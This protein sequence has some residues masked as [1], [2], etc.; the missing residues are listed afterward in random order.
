MYSK[1]LK[2]AILYIN[3]NECSFAVKR[4]V[5][6]SASARSYEKQ[7]DS[8]CNCALKTV[9]IKKCYEELEFWLVLTVQ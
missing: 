6:L 1:Y 9:I 4:N 5:K 2:R 3:T 7:S 8:K